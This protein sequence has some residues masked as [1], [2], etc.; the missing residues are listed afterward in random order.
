MKSHMLLKVFEYVLLPILTKN[1]LLC[2]QQLGYTVQSSCTYTVTIIIMK[3][4]NYAI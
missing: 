3:V 1:L 2:D 4:K